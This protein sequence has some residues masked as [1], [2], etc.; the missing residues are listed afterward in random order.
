M[1]E[2]PWRTATTTLPF[3][4][5]TLRTSEN[6]LHVHR[7]SAISITQG[8]LR[9]SMLRAEVLPVVATKRT[10]KHMQVSVQFNGP[11]DHT[12]RLVGLGHVSV[13]II[14]GLSAEPGPNPETECSDYRSSG[15]G[16][17]PGLA[18]VVL[19]ISPPK[20]QGE[21]RAGALT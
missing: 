9:C 16:F 7:L 15:N 14:R 1:S 6:A 10:Q 12:R 17:R 20:G 4:H 21:P 8:A 19:S 5:V 13:C 2:A 18:A 3:I 11:I